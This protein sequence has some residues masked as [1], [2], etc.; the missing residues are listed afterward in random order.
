MVIQWS[1]KARERVKNIYLF[2]RERSE[3]VATEM[4]GDF[5]NAAKRLAAYPQMAPREPF[6]ADFSKTYRS[7]IVRKYFKI[8]YFVNEEKEEI[9]IAT[10]WDNRQDPEKLKFEIDE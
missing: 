3:R 1:L 4:L 7:F 10:V 8:I 6:L 5:N 9:V 2:Y